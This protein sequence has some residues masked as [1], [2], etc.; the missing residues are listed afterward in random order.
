[1]TPLQSERIV[2]ASQAVRGR[3]P[4]IARFSDVAS[5]SGWTD[6]GQGSQN[7]YSR[8]HRSISDAGG[9]GRR[10]WNRGG[11]DYGGSNV[12][13]RTEPW[14]GGQGYGRGRQ[15][16]NYRPAHL[17]R[18][19]KGQKG[20]TG[21]RNKGKGG[22]ESEEFLQ[23]MYARDRN[24]Q[25]A[26]QGSRSAGILKSLRSM[27][28]RYRERWGELRSAWTEYFESSAEVRPRLACFDDWCS[29]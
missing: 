25:V 2:R 9:W 11:S 7:N 21:R 23:H 24:S 19:G 22:N 26:Q 28:R 8:A 20:Q 29:G 27:V 18:G 13:A 4:D 15:Q 14:N 1:M 5:S 6:Y 12:S 10:D 17:N 3:E 16:Y